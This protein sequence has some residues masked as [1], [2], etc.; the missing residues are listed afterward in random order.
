MFKVQSV[1]IYEYYSATSSTKTAFTYYNAC[2]VQI[3]MHSFAEV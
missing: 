2:T 1:L 3:Y